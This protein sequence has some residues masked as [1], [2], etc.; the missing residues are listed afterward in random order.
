MEYYC[1]DGF[2]YATYTHLIP[3]LYTN[4]KKKKNVAKRNPR[5]F[6]ILDREEKKNETVPPFDVPYETR[7]FCISFHVFYIMLDSSNVLES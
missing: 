4:K 2:S 5:V 6:I 1:F 7:I 3:Y